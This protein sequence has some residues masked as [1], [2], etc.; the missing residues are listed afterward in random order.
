MFLS[1]KEIQKMVRM[2]KRGI[3]SET[4]CNLHKL[5]LLFTEY[6]L[7][8]TKHVCFLNKLLLNGLLKVIHLK[9]ITE[10]EFKNYNHRIFILMKLFS[11]GKD[12]F[13]VILLIS[14]LLC[15]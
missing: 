14:V 5:L 13:R 11:K 8:L 9:Y 1:I 7:K 6:L 12:Y 4:Q 2:K 3:I 10:S 15:S